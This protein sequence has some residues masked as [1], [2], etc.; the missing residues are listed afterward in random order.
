MPR[1]VRAVGGILL[2]T[3]EMFPSRQK[4]ATF[5]GQVER[6]GAAVLRVGAALEQAALL[7]RIDEGDHP[8]GRDL[9]ALADRLLGCSWSQA[10]TT[11][12]AP[13]VLFE[14]SSIRMKLPVLRFSA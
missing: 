7:Q 11:S 1:D 9:Q 6:A 13:T 12:P 4:L 3:P 2:S 5:V 14:A 8:A 10:A